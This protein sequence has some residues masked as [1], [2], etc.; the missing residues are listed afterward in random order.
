VGRYLAAFA[1]SCIVVFGLFLFMHRMVAFAEA[2]LQE[3]QGMGRIDFVRLRRDATF[4][5]KKRELPQKPTQ[6]QQQPDAPKMQMPSGGGAGAISVAAPEAAIDGHKVD[7]GGLDLGGAPSDTDAVPV[8]RVEP[9]YPHIAA[10][11]GLEGWVL[12]EFDIGPS[13][14]VMKAR[15]LESDP[16]RIFD[17]AALNAV[18]KWKYKAQVKDG[19]PLV[20]RGVTVRLTFKLER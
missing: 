13:G 7:L 18:K 4:E 20:T 6:K 14:N 3:R 9:I 19:K 5:K 17:E 11:R 2:S 8:V 15:V 10:Q 1:V 12:L 16:P